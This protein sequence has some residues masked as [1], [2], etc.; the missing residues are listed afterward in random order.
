M[1]KP[2]ERREPR[3]E[4]LGEQDGPPER[5]LKD[6][7]R[8]ELRQFPKVKRA[9]LARVG[10]APDATPAVALCLAPSGT[11][12]RTVV[13]RVLKVFASLFSANSYIDVLFP[14][15]EQELDLQRVCAPFFEIETLS[16]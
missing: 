16:T 13:D 5:E 7:L 2:T 4:F 14:S 1:R 9:Y 10:Y 3:V 11:E 8:I 15:A 12:D 6:A